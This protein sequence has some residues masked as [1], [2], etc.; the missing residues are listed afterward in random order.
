MGK[1]NFEI[2]RAYSTIR[3]EVRDNVEKLMVHIESENARTHCGKS[4]ADVGSL[5]KINADLLE[6]L[7]FLGI[8]K[9]NE[10][11]KN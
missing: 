5:N 3:S 1:R 6:A 11:S 10:S 4:W 8:G 2:E 9:D 7:R